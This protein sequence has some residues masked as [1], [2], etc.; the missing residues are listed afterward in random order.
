MWYNSLIKAKRMGGLLM[1]IA[2]IGIIGTAKST[3]RI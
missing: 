2:K 3:V 1:R